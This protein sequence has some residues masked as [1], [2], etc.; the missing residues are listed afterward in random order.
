MCRVGSL[1]KLR[2][3]Q[4]S[5][6]MFDIPAGVK[7]NADFDSHG[8]PLPKG[9]QHLEDNLD[10]QVHGVLLRAPQNQV[11]RSEVFRGL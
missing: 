11:R 10:S 6:T 8:D 4:L 1:A 9:A 3:V 5:D 7:A 2:L